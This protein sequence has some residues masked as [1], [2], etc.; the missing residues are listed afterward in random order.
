[1]TKEVDEVASIDDAMSQGEIESVAASTEDSN[2][3]QETSHESKKVSGQVDTEPGEKEIPP[4]E[5][6]SNSSGYDTNEKSPSKSHHH[7]NHNLNEDTL[8]MVKSYL[9]S[10]QGEYLDEDAIAVRILRMDRVTSERVRFH[11][12]PCEDSEEENDAASALRKAYQAAEEYTIA[13]D[14]YKKVV[15]G[16]QEKN[17]DTPLDKRTLNRLR[18]AMG[19]QNRN[20]LWET[21]AGQQGEKS[22]ES[23]DDA[24]SQPSKKGPKPRRLTRGMARSTR[25]RKQEERVTRENMDLDALMSAVMDLEEEFGPIPESTSRVSTTCDFL[26][27]SHFTNHCLTYTIHVIL[28]RRS[29]RDR[30]VADLPRIPLRMS[31][32]N[33]TDRNTGPPTGHRN[34]SIRMNLIAISS[35]N[36]PNQNKKCQKVADPCGE[37]IELTVTDMS[38]FVLWLAVTIFDM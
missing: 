26:D 22:D 4:N 33:A 19:L 6:G 24:G 21:T 2:T 23:D 9:Q 38:K 12:D 31:A 18:K 14:F 36:S 8:K 11:H 35:R 13:L 15:A 1:M 29:A 16:V 34:W 20:D 3:T 28:I 32:K 25:I 37:S 17:P 5:A 7:R 27:D 30:K 10:D